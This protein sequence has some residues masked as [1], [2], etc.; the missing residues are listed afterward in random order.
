LPTSSASSSAAAPHAE[1]AVS[2]TTPTGQGVRF[3]LVDDDEIFSSVMA[4]SLGR[5][6]HTAEVAAD[7][8]QAQAL[9]RASSFDI[10]VVDLKLE[11]ESGLNLIPAL[12]VI[13]PSARILMLTGYASIATAVE[14]VKRGADNYLPKPAAA[15]DV[16]RVMGLIGD[17]EGP[18]IEQRPLNPDRLKWEHIQ[19]VLA[20]HEYN[21]SATARALGMHRRTLQRILAKRP[22]AERASPH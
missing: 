18:G 16:L 13:R 5:R 1:I 2:T 8:N 4:R 7:G 6:G 14:A 17:R 22:V 21:I 19:R 11:N 15:D 3:L 12:K 10:V 20:E 9:L